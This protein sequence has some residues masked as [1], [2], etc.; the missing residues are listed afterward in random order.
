VEA[1]ANNTVTLHEE[2]IAKENLKGQGKY[3]D[4]GEPTSVRRIE[5]EYCC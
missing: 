2:A 4:V 3:S 1:A 5:G